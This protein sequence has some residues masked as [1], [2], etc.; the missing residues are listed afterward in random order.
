[1]PINETQL[2]G[3]IATLLDRMNV[4][5]D[6]HA[7]MKGAFVSGQGQPDILVLPTG[8]RPVVI[9]NEYLPARTLE[10]EAIA[11]LG[12]ELDEDVTGVDGE[13][14]AVVALKSPRELRGI[15]GFDKLDEELRSKTR[16]EY[17]VFYGSGS[18]D[19]SRFPRAVLFRGIFGTW[20][21]SSPMR[22]RLRRLCRK[23]W[24]YWSVA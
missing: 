11:R 12:E 17:C 24:R 23:V 1:M 19:Y 22:R 3:R 16:F 6:V 20:R 7:E 9:E 14:N 15:R 2:N 21:D 4:R 10:D 8:G 13:V 18:A 5:W